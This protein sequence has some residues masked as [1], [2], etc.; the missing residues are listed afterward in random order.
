M[1]D[2][3]TKQKQDTLPEWTTPEIMDYDIDEVTNVNTGSGV[4]GGAY[5]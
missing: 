3:A 4:D 2:Q 5:S 1:D